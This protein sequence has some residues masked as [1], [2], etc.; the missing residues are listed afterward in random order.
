[1]RKRK[2]GRS[3]IVETAAV[4]F[5]AGA[6]A[7]ATAVWGLSRAGPTGEP[8]TPATDRVLAAEPRCITT[9]RPHELRAEAI[10]RGLLPVGYALSEAA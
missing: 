5:F 4:A 3:T 10:A 7:M 8:D 9:D 6:V 2:P 1:M